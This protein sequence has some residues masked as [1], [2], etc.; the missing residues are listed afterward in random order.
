MGDLGFGFDREGAH[1]GGVVEV[2]GP[3]LASRD[4]RSA[5]LRPQYHDVDEGLRRSRFPSSRIAPCRSTHLAEYTRRLTEVFEKNGTK[6]TW[7]AHASEGCLHVRPVLNL[8]LEK[9]VNAMRAIAE[10][11]FALV[12]EYKGSHSGEHGDGLVRSEFHKPMFGE[13][14]VSAFE[15]VKA[16]FD[17]NT[18]LN[19][20]KIVHP[21]RFDDRSL[22]RYGPDYSVADIT[23]RLDWSEFP[24]AAGWPAGGG[25]DVQQ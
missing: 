25:G 13:R 1:W 6:G 24:G 18:A 2:H 5:H 11:A 23:P 16:I 21:P 15:E 7:Y 22:L 17:P 8:R 4:H 20:G 19:P 14:L 10:E 3:G 9:D 12:R